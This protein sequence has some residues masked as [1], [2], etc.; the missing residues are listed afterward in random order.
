[1]AGWPRRGATAGPNGAAGPEERAEEVMAVSVLAEEASPGVFGLTEPQLEE[2][3]LAVVALWTQGAWPCRERQLDA[4]PE[5]CLPPTG[6]PRLK[7]TQ[8]C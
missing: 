1:M 3:V 7:R 6:T 8:N 2:V 4:P 5:G